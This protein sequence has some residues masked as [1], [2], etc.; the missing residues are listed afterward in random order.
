MIDIRFSL[1]PKQRA[2]Q[3][4]VDQK[5][6]TFYGGAK[7]GGKSK[8]VRDI[9]LLRRFQYPGTH[10]GLF[11]RTYKELEGNHIRPLLKEYPMLRPYWVD[12]KKLLTLPNGST[13]EFCHAENE[14]DVDLYQGREF[15]DLAIEEAGQW[16]EPMFR[17]LLGSN[18]SSKPGFKPRCLLTGNPGG[19]GH[20]WLK[21]IFIERRFNERERPNDYA[22]IQALVD[23]NPALIQNDP[24]YVHKLDSEPNEALRKAYR[25]GDWDIFAGQY[26]GEI[27][28]EVHFIPPFAIPKHWQRFGSYD[29][30]FNHPAAFGWFACDS[31]GNVY[32]YREL[33]KAQKRVD[34]FALEMKKHEDTADLYMVVGGLDCWTKKNV[35]N[36]RSPPTIAEEFA[37]HDIFLTRA[38]VDR[39]QGASQLRNYLA[40]QNLSSGR[41]KPRFFIF[42]NCP[43]TFDCI[44][45]MQHDPDHIEDVLKVDASEGD[46]LTGDDA[47]D[48]IRYALM[49]RPL[50][51]DEPR[52]YAKPGTPEHDKQFAEALFDHNMA[53]LKEAKENREG[54]SINWKVDNDM[55]PDWNKW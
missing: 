41:T 10:G 27:R 11:R 38:I 5:P 9:M 25:Y 50:L 19:I 12:G 40:W 42:N 3:E 24:D 22:F 48:M 34:Q 43:I 49:S 55:T 21:R 17:K 13:L 35:I 26:F 36:D 1:Q 37:K 15:E 4:M 31:D 44:S 33:I 53:R 28:R 47:Y 23:D 7:G 45:R 30:G 51:T 14:N 8:G 39:V 2:F 32:L 52:V 18:R 20:T 29:F 16:T 6:I 54:T 46:P